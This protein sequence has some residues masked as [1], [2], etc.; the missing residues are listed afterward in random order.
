MGLGSLLELVGLMRFRV[1]HYLVGPTWAAH[2]FHMGCTGV[3]ETWGKALRTQ[4][5]SLVDTPTRNLYMKMVCT[6]K[7]V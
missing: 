6:D 3:M 4:R 2:G 5:C 1:S 7:D